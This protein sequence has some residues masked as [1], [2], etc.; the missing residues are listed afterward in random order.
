MANVKKYLSRSSINKSTSRP[1][2]CSLLLV[3]TEL[4]SRVGSG[5]VSL[6]LLGFQAHGLRDLS[7][8]RNRLAYTVYP[9]LA[10]RSGA[11]TTVLQVLKALF[12][13]SFVGAS[14]R[15]TKAASNTAE[16][17]INRT[18]ATRKQIAN[19]RAF[20]CRTRPLEKNEC[21]KS[22]EKNRNGSINY[23]SLTKDIS[24]APDGF[25][26]SAGSP[27]RLRTLKSMTLAKSTYNSI[28]S[29]SVQSKPQTL[30]SST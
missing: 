11:P 28:I 29:W 15:N 27:Y 4:G 9:R 21:A 25:T 22:L 16:R 17:P 12:A 1:A 23:H 13:T 19:C 24:S 10:T 26:F 14:P 18:H 7:I 2:V 8:S 30:R 20:R 5:L 6:V 3:L